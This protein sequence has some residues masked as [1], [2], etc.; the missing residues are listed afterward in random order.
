MWFVF[1]YYLYVVVAVL[2]L[3]FWDSKSFMENKCLENQ[4]LHFLYYMKL[5][6]RSI[7]DIDRTSEMF[8]RRFM[9]VVLASAIV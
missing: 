3:V 8:R 1:V 2:A 9:E 7:A 4:W 5:T 6:A